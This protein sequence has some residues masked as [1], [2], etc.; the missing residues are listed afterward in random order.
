MSNSINVVSLM[1]RTSPDV[2]SVRVYEVDDT[3]T[4]IKLSDTCGTTDPCKRQCS[5]DFDVVG[6]IPLFFTCLF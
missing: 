1:T 4:G 6:L 5:H 2:V 3:D